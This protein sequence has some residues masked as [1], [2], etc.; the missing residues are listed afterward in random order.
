MAVQKVAIAQGWAPSLVRERAQLMPHF[1]RAGLT[2]VP[3]TQ[4]DYCLCVRVGC[5]KVAAKDGFL[6]SHPNAQLMMHCWL[7]LPCDHDCIVVSHHQH[8]STK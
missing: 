4:L 8:F 1:C 6:S 2:R 7:V 3:C 5:L